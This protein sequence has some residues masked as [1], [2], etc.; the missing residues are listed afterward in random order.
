MHLFYQPD[1]STLQLPDD[2]AHHAMKVLRLQAGDEIEITDG[3]GLWALAK[4]KVITKTTCTFEI[5]QKKFIG[6]RKFS[7]HL[8]IAPTKNI[9]RIEWMLEK[10]I[11]LGIEKITLLSTQHSE[12]R[13]VNLERLTKIT[14]AAMKQS[15][16]VWLPLLDETNF[17]ELLQTEASQKFIAHV[18]SAN[19]ELLQKVAV[20]LGHYLILIGPEGDFS[21]D[22]VNQAM[23]YGFKKVSLGPTRLRTETAGLAAC[24]ILNLINQ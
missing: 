18:D 20:P 13:K 12:R 5:L 14:T 23:S 17:A 6:P 3:M 8:A 22:E 24:H 2:E 4:I 1:L 9:D 19:P 7:I 16:Q 21:N 10:C 15:Q 11:E